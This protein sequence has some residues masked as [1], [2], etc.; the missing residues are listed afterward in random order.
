M[1]EFL[2]WTPIMERSGYLLFLELILT[3]IYTFPF[4]TSML[5]L[6]MDLNIT[7]SF[8]VP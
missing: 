2:D 1:V 8:T 7:F 5:K 4:P 6:P 3:W